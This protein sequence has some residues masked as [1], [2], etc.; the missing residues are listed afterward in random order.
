MKLTIEEEKIRKVLIDVAKRGSTISYG[1]LL[2][3]AGLD[4][5]Y[6]FSIN[7]YFRIEFGE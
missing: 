1:R 5:K 3:R 6:D 2:R 4:G 7:P